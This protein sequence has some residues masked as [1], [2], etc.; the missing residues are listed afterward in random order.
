MICVFRGTDN[1]K[2]VNQAIYGFSRIPGGGFEPPRDCSHCDLNAA[3]LPIPPLRRV[4]VNTL[5][6]LFQKTNQTKRFF[7][8]ERRKK[9]RFV[10]ESNRESV[11]IL[12]VCSRLHV[13][14]L[15]FSR[16]RK[17]A[18][19]SEGRRGRRFRMEQEGE[20]LGGRRRLASSASIVDELRW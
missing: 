3:R 2:A 11:G 12:L 16:L 6:R 8:M 13:N 1:K 14:C 7:F 17:T 9:V 19:P 4:N 5:H 10:L 18:V 15:I 20:L